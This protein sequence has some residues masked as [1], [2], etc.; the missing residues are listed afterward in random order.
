MD[1]YVMAVP[2]SD[3]AMNIMTVAVLLVVEKGV[4]YVLTK[5]GECFLSY[6]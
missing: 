3:L 2:Y 6:R 5:L 1:G 4:Y